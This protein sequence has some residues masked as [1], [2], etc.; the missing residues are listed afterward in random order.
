LFM[1]GGASLQFSL[2]PMNLL[3]DGGHAA[4]VTTGAWSEK[5]LAEAKKLGNAV[6]V[7][8]TAENG[9]KSVPRP[10]QIEFGGES[11]YVHYCSNETIHGVEFDYDLS[12]GSVP[13][14]CDA[15]SNILSKPI[16]ITKYGLIY[17]GAQKNIGPSGLTVVIIRD[18]LLER[19]PAGLPTILDYRVF[20][21]ERSMPN[22]PNTWGIYLI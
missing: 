2:I 9:Y 11:D 5:A 22:T 14:I 4:Y 18:D 12:A 21:N 3:T 20:A 17:A 15:S 19:I 13:V 7:F 16:N 8:T 6:E 1:S 10:Q